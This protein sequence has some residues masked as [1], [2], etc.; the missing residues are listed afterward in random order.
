MPTNVTTKTGPALSSGAGTDAPPPPLDLPGT[1]ATAFAPA[2]VS[3]SFSPG[4]A[5]VTYETCHV[6]RSSCESEA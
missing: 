5:V 3:A 1:T 6:R 4:R 2:E